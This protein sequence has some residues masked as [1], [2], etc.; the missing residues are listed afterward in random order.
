MLAVAAAAPTAVDKNGCEGGG[1]L[2][3]IT[4]VVAVSYAGLQVLNDRTTTKKC[5]DMDQ[6]CCFFHFLFTFPLKNVIKRF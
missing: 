5:T 3:W 6:Y 1:Q 2:L 4:G